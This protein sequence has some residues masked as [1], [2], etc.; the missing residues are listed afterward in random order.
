MNLKNLTIKIDRQFWNRLYILYYLLIGIAM[1]FLMRP[2]ATIPLSVRMALL[3]L[4]LMPVCFRRETLPFAMLCFYGIS[5]NSFLNVLPT[6]HLYYLFI[7]LAFYVVYRNKSRSFVYAL[8]FYVYFLACCIVQDDMQKYLIWWIVSLVL[9]DYVKDVLDVRNL[10]YAFMIISIFLSALFLL[11]QEDFIEAYGR[12]EEGLERSSWIN[13]N[14]FGATIAAGAILSVAYLTNVLQLPKSKVLFVLSIITVAL[15]FVVLILN[16]SRGAFFAF[17]IP[18]VMMM[19]LSKMNTIYKI[20]IAVV[21]IFAVY[22]LYNN[23]DVFELLITRMEDD[24]LDSGGNRTDIWKEKLESFFWDNNFW[25]RIVGMGR[26]DCTELRN[27]LSTHNDF[28]T[29]FIGYGVIG[30][31]LFTTVFFLPIIK[32]KK[33]M[34]LSV[35]LLMLYLLIE[36]FV[37]E[38]L[39]RG[40]FVEIM[41]YFFV[42]KYALL[43]EKEQPADDMKKTKKTSFRL[44]ARLRFKL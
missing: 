20:L 19:F 2:N 40:Y 35:A 8:F 37:L 13:A 7:V 3:G 43:V 30:L 1:F 17:I 11:Y 14:V 38:P 12:A 6:S 39:F 4:I 15:S 25:H 32:A 31:I 34:R 42:L 33:G 5:S 22:W 9:Y 44:F 24:T 16:A 27:Q 26:N 21:A 10:L 18:G 29:A 41:F 28:L 23:T 36:C